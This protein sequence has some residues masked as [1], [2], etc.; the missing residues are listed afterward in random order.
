MG[1]WNDVAITHVQ[2]V[3][4]YVDGNFVE[5]YNEQSTMTKLVLLSFFLRRLISHFIYLER[6]CEYS[7]PKVLGYFRRFSRFSRTSGHWQKRRLPGISPANNCLIFFS[8]FLGWWCQ[9]PARCYLCQCNG[10]RSPTL[11][12]SFHRLHH[13]SVCYLLMSTLTEL[14]SFK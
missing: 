3:V 12:Q 6:F 9:I 14:M 4:H 2:V 10:R 1:P 5:A 11:Q 7:S 8:L 13:G